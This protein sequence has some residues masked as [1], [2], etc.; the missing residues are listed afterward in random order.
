MS[1]RWQR[2]PWYNWSKLGCVSLEARRQSE[3]CRSV[4]APSGISLT[5]ALE[6]CGPASWVRKTADSL[7]PPRY[8]CNGNVLLMTWPSYC[9]QEKLIIAP[10]SGEFLPLVNAILA[11]AGRTTSG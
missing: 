9:F 6:D 2:P 3:S 1:A 8:R 4:D 5:T 7:E 10:Q 11:F